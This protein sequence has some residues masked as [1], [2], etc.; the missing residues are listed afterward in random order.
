MATGKEEEGTYLRSLPLSSFPEPYNGSVMLHYMLQ[1]NNYR[2]LRMIA[3]YKHLDAIETEELVMMYWKPRY[4][5]PN[6]E[7]L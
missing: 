2:L 6:I 7:E 1:Q 3:R 4:Y 5:V